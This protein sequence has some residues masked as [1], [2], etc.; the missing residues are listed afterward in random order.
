MWSGADFSVV[1]AQVFTWPMF[2]LCLMCLVSG[3]AGV[4]SIAGKYPVGPHGDPDPHEPLDFDSELATVGF[5]TIMVGLT[6]GVIC[7][8]RIGSTIAMF[9][10]GGTHRVGLLFGAIFIGAVFYSGAPIGKYTPTWFLGGLFMQTGINFL[11][12]VIL[13][14]RTPA[15]Y[16][17]TIFC[18]FVSVFSSPI[19]AGITSEKIGKGKIFGGFKEYLEGMWGHPSLAKIQ[20]KTK[21]TQEK[22]KQKHTLKL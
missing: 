14:Y 8:H 10:S 6:G 15:Q 7:L 21:N 13:Q 5:G 16:S 3:T 9:D 1:V 11:K 18:I 22:A 17:V 12:G 19:K 20:R 4:A 2:M